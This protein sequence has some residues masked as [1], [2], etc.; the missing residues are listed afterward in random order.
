MSVILVFT[1]AL[2]VLHCAMV[3]KSRGRLPGG[4]L[5]ADLALAVVA[6]FILSSAAGLLL[7]LAWWKELGQVQ[8][9]WRFVDIAWLPQVAA[10]LAGMLVFLALAVVGGLTSSTVLSLFLVPV[11]Y[12][13]FAGEPAGNPEAAVSEPCPEGTGA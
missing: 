7:E 12:L 4:V 8:T 13:F 9:F 2:V 10:G 1:L 6:A 3:A 11:M 5:L